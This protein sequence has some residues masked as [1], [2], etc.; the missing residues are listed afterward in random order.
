MKTW[1]KWLAECGLEFKRTD[2]GE[3][4][5]HE[6]DFGHGIKV[7]KGEKGAGSRGGMVEVNGYRTSHG[8][9]KALI[10]RILE[11]LDEEIAK[12]VVNTNVEIENDENIKITTENIKLIIKKDEETNK[13]GRL[14][15]QF[16]TEGQLIS[17][18]HR[19]YYRQNGFHTNNI[20]KCCKGE[21]KTVNG[22][23]WRYVTITGN[24]SNGSIKI[25][26]LH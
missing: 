17:V 20:S 24:L 26:F 19:N 13:K 8:S 25:S 14:I 23:I 3:T 16:S 4:V 2:N 1:L 15:A 22:Y 12:E 9:V 6:Y 7:F 10:E 21:L 5:F 18:N 11:V